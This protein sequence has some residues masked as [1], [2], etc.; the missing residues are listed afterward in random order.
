MIYSNLKNSKKEINEIVKRAKNRLLSA[1]ILLKNG[2]YA[3]SIS[4]S[5]YAFLDIAQAA[6]IKLGYRTKSHAGTITLFSKHF[7]KSRSIDDKYIIFFKQAKKFREEADYEFLKKFTKE[8]AELVLKEAK[9]FVKTVAKKI[10]K[11]N[12]N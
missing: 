7:V 9:D 5:Y 2:Q 12:N 4:R 11:I 1:K 8:E 3:D 10:L 6:L